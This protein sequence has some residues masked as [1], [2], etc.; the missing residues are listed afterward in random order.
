MERSVLWYYE[1]LVLNLLMGEE[2]RG[3]G[4]GR[5]QR[6]HGKKCIMILFSLGLTDRGNNYGEETEGG[7]G[8]GVYIK[9]QCLIKENKNK[10]TARF[11]YSISSFSFLP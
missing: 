9:T 11:G 5:R 1:S 3:G 10:K 7:K 8:R 2:L 6:K 4:G